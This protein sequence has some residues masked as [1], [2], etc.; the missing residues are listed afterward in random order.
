[1]AAVTLFLTS[2]TTWTVPPDFSVLLGVHCYG[3]GGSS[4]A[5]GGT[6]G[7]TGGF[8][9]AYASISSTSTILTP[10]VTSI[11][12]RVGTSDGDTWWNATSLANAVANG[13][14]ASCAA[15]GGTNSAAGAAAS[16]VGTI[17]FSGGNP[18]SGSGGN[19]GGGGGSGG[20]RGAGGSGTASTGGTAN[21]GTV[22][23]NS[24]GTEFDATHGSGA[25]SNGSAG[26]G[27]TGKSYGGGASGGAQG[28]FAGASGAPGLIVIIYAPFIFRRPLRFR[29][30]IEKRQ[31][32]AY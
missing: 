20:P 4:S 17:K 19:G 29:N 6:I 11:S 12:Y 5:G 27:A 1:M 10:G 8:G 25:G 9:A 22:A 18:G 31:G 23:A 26:A 16:S 3:G 32:F 15:Q 2:G 28:S 30:F 14:A 13:P 21:G 24:S 7:G